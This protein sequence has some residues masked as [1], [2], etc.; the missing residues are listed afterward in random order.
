MSKQALILIDL[1][2]D[3]FASG[4]WPLDNIEPAAANAARVLAAFRQAGKPVIHVRH[5][6]LA[7][8]APFFRSGTPG[9]QIHGAVAPAANEPVIV[10]HYPNSF[11]ETELHAVLAQHGIES[12]VLVG[13]MSHMCIEAAGRAAAD[14]G[15]GVTVLHDACATRE[16]VFDGHT[17]PAAQVHAGAMAALAFGYAQLLATEAFLAQG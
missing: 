14:L 1:Q 12:L 10:K 17:V 13:A 7:A 3:Y 2:H 6:S 9:A 16:L 4:L 5:E 11:R 15:Y 8:D